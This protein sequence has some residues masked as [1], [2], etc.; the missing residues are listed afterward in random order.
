MT[1]RPQDRRDIAEAFGADA[2]RYDRA[3]PRYP[4]GVADAV[5]DGLPAPRMLDVGIGT[6]ISALTF[7]DAGAEVSGVEVD[8]RMA[9]IARL[10]GFPVDVARFE[11]WDA[12]D[13]VFDAVVSGQAWHWVDAAAGTAA[14]AR[15]LRPGGRLALFWN[16]GEP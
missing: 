16:V 13:S 12:G 6:G 3:R 15:V 7:R 11:D 4:R 5:L 10:R 8:E 9:E 14:A 2:E 1:E